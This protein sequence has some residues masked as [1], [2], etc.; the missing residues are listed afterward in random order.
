MMASRNPKQTLV[1]EKNKPIGKNAMRAIKILIESVGALITGICT[2]Q[3]E[4]A[5]E[6]KNRLK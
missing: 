1:Y 4:I 3:N 2:M 5:A 6:N